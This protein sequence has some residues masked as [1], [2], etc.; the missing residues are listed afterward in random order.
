MNNKKGFTLVE[1]LAVIA[2]LAI[3][4]LIALPNVMGMFNDAKKNSFTTELKEVYKVA[5][6]TWVSDSLFNTSEKIYS[7]TKAQNCSNQLDLTGRKELEYFIKINKAGNVVEYYASDGTYQY[8]YKGNGLLITDISN[9]E[10]ISDIA[11][12]QINIR[13]NRVTVNERVADVNSKLMLGSSSN[14][15]TNYL[16]T[17]IAKKDIEKITFTNSLSDHT[18]N[19]IDC[20]DV[21]YGNNGS[22]LAWVVDNDSNGKY[23][24]TIG[25][26]GNVYVSNGFY[27]F[28]YL[29][30]L[31]SIDGMQYFRTN[32]ITSMLDMFGDCK[33]LA[34]LDLSYFDTSNV[35]NMNDMFHNCQSFTSL[36][37]SSFD[38]SNVATFEQMFFYC[39][40]LQSINLSSF[41]TSGA[42]SMYRMFYF[43][44]KLTSINLSNFNTSNVKDMSEMFDSCTSLTSLDLS[45]FD[46]SNV[47]LMAGM[48]DYILLTTLDL[49]NFVTSN[50]TDMGGM[51][52]GASNLTT[53]DLSNF[54][55]SK[56]KNMSGMFYGCI[57]L[58]TLNLSSFD[59]SKVTNMNG[60]FKNMT[61][62]EVL[63]LSSFDT[64]SVTQ[65]Y[66]SA[67]TGRNSLVADAGMFQNCRKLGVIYVSEEFVTTNVTS[68]EGMFTGC[69]S[70]VG[71]VG[72]AYNA[73]HVN[74]TY[75][76]IDGGTSNPG[77]F[78]SRN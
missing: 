39:N 35:T 7:R 15:T 19:G 36:D 22:V 51:F 46:T 25:S 55:T 9:V 27:Q 66:G 54:D 16:R 70:L 29:T 47:E 73:S 68:S 32:N 10:Q 71:G 41:I 75:A 4:V 28:A 63:D 69:T 64:S 58:T 76:H 57:S 48:F 12:G 59:T 24:M 52:Y 14:E 40:N 21:S 50:V 67:S 33:K 5:E 72:T 18:P 11:D 43:C 45:N 61:N 8:S 17:N 20:F 42:T 26:N 77:Y 3:L 23:E 65:F 44:K 2:I 78:T 74:A 53:L 60:M 37:L 34:S 1:L 49:S 56:V 13:C 6:Q 38:T 62:I 30:N 31:V